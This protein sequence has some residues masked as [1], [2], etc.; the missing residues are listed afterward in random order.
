MSRELE[1]ADLA[2]PKRRAVGELKDGPPAD[3]DRIVA[4]DR[5]QHGGEGRVANHG[6]VAD[7]GRFVLQ[8]A[9]GE[10]RISPPSSRNPKYALSMPATFA[11]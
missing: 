4:A 11:A 5:V 7:T 2:R 9:I 3:A 10:E 1:V 8:P 6:E